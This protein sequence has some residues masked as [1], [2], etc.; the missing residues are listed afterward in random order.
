[1]LCAPGR[2]TTRAAGKFL[3]ARTTP[4]PTGGPPCGTIRGTIRGN[5]S[6]IEL[7]SQ[8]ARTDP[9]G[10]WR[11][12]GGRG[13]E[14]GGR[15]WRSDRGTLLQSFSFPVRLFAPFVNSETTCIVAYIHRSLGIAPASSNLARSRHRA[16]R[17]GTTL[18][19]WARIED[20]SRPNSDG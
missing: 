17:D 12:G 13:R 4:L 8:R 1:M 15:G 16:C 10:G 19:L 18:A 2:G 3:A 20:P 14:G 7:C 6:E 5:S 11:E 9:D